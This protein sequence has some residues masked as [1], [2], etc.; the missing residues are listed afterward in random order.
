MGAGR[1]R[2][3]ITEFTQSSRINPERMR[4]N[5]VE[6]AE[7]C[8]IL[9][10]PDIGAPE[11]LDAV[12]DAWPDGRALVFCDESAESGDAMAA[13]K[14]IKHERIAI[15]IGPEGGFSEPE[16]ARLTALPFVT[17]ISLGPRILRADTAAVA[18]L[19]LVQ[20]VIGDWVERR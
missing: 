18:A 17:P 13:L 1:L 11:K 9:A 16:R 6:A 7:Q 15:L 3:V 12:L 8:G 20:A 10:I 5:A 14:G 19:A 2:P 4:A